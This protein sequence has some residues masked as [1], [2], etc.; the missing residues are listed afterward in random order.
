MCLHVHDGSSQ[1]NFGLLLDSKPKNIFLEL[2]IEKMK[3][4]NIMGCIGHNQSGER[5]QQ[6]KEKKCSRKRGK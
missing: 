1:P 6:G 5:R 2:W 3:K 4:E